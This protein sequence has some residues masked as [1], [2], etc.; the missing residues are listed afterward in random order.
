MCATPVARNDHR[1]PASRS[2]LPSPADGRPGRMFMHRL[3]WDECPHLPRSGRCAGGDRAVVV[4]RGVHRCWSSP[5]RP[6]WAGRCGGAWPAQFG[7][8]VAMLRLTWTDARSAGDSAWAPTG[9]DHRARSK[10]GYL[11]NAHGI[12]SLIGQTTG[13]AP[14]RGREWTSAPRRTSARRAAPTRGGGPPRRTLPSRRRGSRR[15]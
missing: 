3:D 4:L 13:G 1:W 5:G 15:G 8:A 12:G 9:A 2:T 6:V 10:P 7:A 14:T 11:C